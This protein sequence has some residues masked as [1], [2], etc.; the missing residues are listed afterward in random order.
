MKTQAIIKRAAINAQKNTTQLDG[1]SAKQLRELWGEVLRDIY[2]VLMQSTEPDGQLRADRLARIKATVENML[3]QHGQAQ[4]NLLSTSLLNSAQLG[5]APFAAYIA[6]QDIPERT[7]Q[8]VKA[9]I[10]NDGLQLSDRI[11]GSVED[12]KAVFN[13]RI[14]TAIVTGQS[15]SEAALQMLIAGNPV[16]DELKN[17]ANAQKVQSVYADIKSEFFDTEYQ[18]MKRV[19]TTEINRAHGVAFEASVAMHPDTV[20]TKF[21][22][23]PNHPKTDICDMHA[24]VNRF[25]LGAGVYPIGKNPWPAHPGTISYTQVVFSDEVTQSDKLTKTDRITWLKKLPAAAQAS[26]LGKNKALALRLGYLK[27]N[28]INTLWRILK[29]RYAQRGYDLDAF[30]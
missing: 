26:V 19:F 8:I 27:E 6:N 21:M 15:A 9:F 22:L 16:S 3:N 1:T 25:G 20:G 18:N 23:S 28:E 17:K 29:D 4:L 11:W 13:K 5:A 12:A 24:K 30:N 14:T 10:A 7:V 2:I